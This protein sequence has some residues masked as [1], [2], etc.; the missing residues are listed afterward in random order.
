MFRDNSVSSPPTEQLLHGQAGALGG[1]GGTDG[2]L[3]AAFRRQLQAEGV[4]ASGEMP[5]SA[6]PTLSST[7]SM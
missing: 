7:F 6:A 2:A 3:L 5:L 4:G 1:G